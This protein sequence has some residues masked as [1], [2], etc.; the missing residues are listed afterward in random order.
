MEVDQ[1]ERTNA[2]EHLADISEEDRLSIFL[3]AQNAKRGGNSVILF[4]GHM[5][6]HH[7]RHSMVSPVFTIGTH[8]MWVMQVHH[9]LCDEVQRM[10]IGSNATS[11]CFH[12]IDRMT[13]SIMP[14]FVAPNPNWLVG[15]KDDIVL[16]NRARMTEGAFHVC[17]E[18]AKMG[19]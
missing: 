3:T 1:K 14:T 19:R 13:Q 6:P 16:P 11:L 10:L 8:E 12:Y 7:K 9:S 17:V 18:T 2:L 15:H 5:E 4:C